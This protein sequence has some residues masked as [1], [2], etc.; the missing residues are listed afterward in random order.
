MIRSPLLDDPAA[1]WSPYDPA[2]DGSWDRSRVAHLHRR[3][4][5]TASWPVLQRDLNDGP[6]A[7]VDRL[8]AGEP[9]GADGQSA[10]DQDA[11]MNVMATQFAATNNLAR[12]Q[13]VWLYR[14]IFT[15]NPLRERM[16]LFWHNHF[17]TS[18]AKVANTSLM[19]AQNELLRRH[20][21]GDFQV[22]LR[23]MARDPAMLAWLDCTANRKAHPNENYAREVME[24]FTLG[25]GRY[26]E[27]DIQQAARA[28]TGSFVQNDRFKDVPAQHDDGEKTIL[29]RT[30]RFKGDDVATILLEQPA[31]AEFLCSKLYRHFVSEVDAPTPE[32]IAPLADCLRKANYEVKAPVEMI[33]RSRLFFSPST[34]RRRVKSPVELA[35]GTIRALEILKPTVSAEALAQATERMGQS[36][37][38]PPS[39][40]GWEGG[41]AWINT[42]TTLARSNFVL[43]I[44]GKDGGLGNRFDAKKLV[45]RHKATDQ[46]DFFV[47]LLVQDAFDAKVRGRIRAGDPATLVMT[48]PEYQLA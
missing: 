25:R 37:Y 12:V 45:E 7:S 20:A 39:V 46:A 10:A 15:V 2:T 35:V 3:A 44:L 31:C 17:A 9:T 14:L 47:D 21:L 29:G 22:M 30:G 40:A 38:T 1:A 16:T 19:Q 42:T 26:T 28:F 32:L 5:F 33:L 24:L 48:S 41:P 36:L 23:E 43:G 4:G 11:M 13:G 6:Q 34:R 8:L 27:V 18:N